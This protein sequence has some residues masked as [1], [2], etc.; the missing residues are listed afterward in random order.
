VGVG[1]LGVVGCRR[2]GHVS[3]VWHP[4]DVGD[5]VFLFDIGSLPGQT[6]NATTTTTRPSQAGMVTPTGRRLIWMQL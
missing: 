4:A 5:R 2:V 1:C 6:T 3:R